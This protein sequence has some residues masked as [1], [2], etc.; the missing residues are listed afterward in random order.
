[1]VTTKNIAILCITIAL[2]IFQISA[3]A[4]PV[5]DGRFDA[6]EGYTQ[7]YNLG[8]W[9]EGG[10]KNN[11]LPIDAGTGELWLYQ[12]PTTHDLFVNFTQPLTLVDNT[13]GINSIGWGK[14]IAPS[15]KNH[16]FNDLVDSDKA[17]FNITD[18]LG[19]IVFDFTLDYI[20]QT[21]NVSSGYASLGASGE[22]GRVDIGSVDS[23]L[24]WCTSLDYNFNTLGYV[25]TVTS[26]ATDQYYT[27]NPDYPG[28]VFEIT[29][30][31]QVAGDLFA[32]NGFGNL[33]V[34]LVHDSPNKIGKNKVHTPEPTTIALLGLGSLMLIRRRTV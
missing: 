34:P 26:P 21:D 3:S 30:E 15:G 23:L 27:E 9:I 28:W 20:S 22:D 13:Y 11:N 12:D 33:T 16:N 4:T 32:N 8:M 5:I 24:A 10:K 25:L 6:G 31:F 7:S 17:Q 29:Y 14:D 19:N 1:M 2:V 18:G